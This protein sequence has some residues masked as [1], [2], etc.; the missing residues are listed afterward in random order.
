[1][2]NLNAQKRYKTGA[3]PMTLSELG[4]HWGIKQ[5]ALESGLLN[6]NWGEWEVPLCL[7]YEGMFVHEEVDG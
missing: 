1:M 3:G 5:D 6:M 7:S 4:L 2:L